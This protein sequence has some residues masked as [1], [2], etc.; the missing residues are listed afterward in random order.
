MVNREAGRWSNKDTMSIVLH[1]VEDVNFQFL[2]IPN[3]YTMYKVNCKS[4]I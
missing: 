4:I 1:L 2:I 3:K